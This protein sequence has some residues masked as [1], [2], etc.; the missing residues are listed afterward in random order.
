M[1]LSDYC[2]HSFQKFQVLS[3][4]VG[5]SSEFAIRLLRHPCP[6]HGDAA[7]TVRE[8]HNYCGEYRGGD[9][10]GGGHCGAKLCHVSTNNK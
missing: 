7:A 5:Y 4:S 1:L 3:I 2:C 9:G 8:Q 6:G 10:G